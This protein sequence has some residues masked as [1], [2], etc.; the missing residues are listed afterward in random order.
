MTDPQFQTFW[1][2]NGKKVTSYPLAEQR[3][4]TGAFVVEV[5]AE[6]QQAEAEARKQRAKKLMA[7]DARIRREAARI[8]YERSPEGQREEALRFAAA[9]PGGFISGRAVNDG[10]SE[11]DAFSRQNTNLLNQ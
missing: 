9:H 5:S 7:E 10:L 4:L 2:C 1:L 8:Q 6:S 11:L 3:C